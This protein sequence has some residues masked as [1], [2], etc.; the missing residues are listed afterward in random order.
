MTPENLKELYESTKAANKEPA[1]YF[2]PDT[3]Q[4]FGD[5]MSN[6]RVTEE[7]IMELVDGAMV[8]VLY[9]VLHRK[10]PVK[11]SYRPAGPAAWFRAYD[12]KISGNAP[13]VTQ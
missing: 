6:Y 7:T 13:G 3:M 11:K 4:F 9:Y 10:R 1:Y 8:E 5:T 12:M 2:R